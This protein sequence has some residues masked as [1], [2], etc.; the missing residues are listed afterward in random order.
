MPQAVSK[1]EEAQTARVPDLQGCA[2]REQP[3]MGW[4]VRGSRGDFS[5]TRPISGASVGTPPAA[6]A[7]DGARK[8]KRPK[9]KKSTQ[10]AGLR[11]KDPRSP[12]SLVV[13]AREVA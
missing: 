12:V 10:Q 11:G 5:P 2:S 6:G 7:G 8:E 1:D 4:V 13:F 3:V 9:E